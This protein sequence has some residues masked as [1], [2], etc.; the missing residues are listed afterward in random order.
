MSTQ[1]SVSLQLQVQQALQNLKAL[2]AQFIK[3]DKEVDDATDELN[4]FEKD[5][6]QNL[7]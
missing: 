2:T 7:L 4:K 1:Y 5:S 6:D 3:F